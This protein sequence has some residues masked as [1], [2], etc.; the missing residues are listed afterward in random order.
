MI[1]SEKTNYIEK[2]KEII[3]N[4]Y[5]KKYKKDVHVPKINYDIISDYDAKNF[6]ISFQRLI[7]SGAFFECESGCYKT[8]I[9]G[10]K[11]YPF[12]RVTKDKEIQ[13]SLNEEWQEINHKYVL[14]IS[15]INRVFKNI[16][17]NFNF[18]C[19]EYKYKKYSHSST[20]YPFDWI[21]F[22]PNKES[23]LFACE[24]RSELLN[25]R[26]TGILDIIDITKRI[27]NK[28]EIFTEKKYDNINNSIDGMRKFCPKYWIAAGPDDNTFIYKLDY[29]EAGP[30]KIEESTFEDL[31]KE[32]EHSQ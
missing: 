14:R 20:T 9:D 2:F 24:V 4:L 16:N 11:W 25:D 6:A 30:I 32:L 10:A 13:N 5:N 31:Y 19:N 27:I 21:Y 3:D 22:Y 28:K 29:D 1:S 26:G 8:K 12:Q 15:L 18:I 17:I 23:S 7:N